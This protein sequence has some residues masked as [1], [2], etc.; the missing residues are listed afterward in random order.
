MNT[1]E[2]WITAHKNIIW[3]SWKVT[4]N[5]DFPSLNKVING[6]MFDFKDVNGAAIEASASERESPISADLSAL[7]SLAPSPHIP[8]NTSFCFNFLIK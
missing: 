2:V 7:Q 8:T 4:H 1:P 5:E 6:E 3:K